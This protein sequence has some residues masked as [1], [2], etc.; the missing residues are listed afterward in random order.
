MNLYERLPLEFL[1]DFYVEIKKKYRT[2][3]S[4]RSYAA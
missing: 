2:R 4:N 3:T 1:A